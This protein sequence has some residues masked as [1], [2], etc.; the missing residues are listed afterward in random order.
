M[1]LYQDSTFC[2]LKEAAPVPVLT[3][4][5]REHGYVSYADHLQRNHVIPVIQDYDWKQ[6]FGYAGEPDV[7]PSPALSW[8]HPEDQVSLVRF[9]RRDVCRVYYFIEGV[10]NET[11]WL[12]VG[13]LFDGRFFALRA[14]CDYT[15]WG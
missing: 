3:D 12:C 11:N 2:A 1:K 8:A 10:R 5:L 6:A 4:W 13:E 15:G 9:T 14:W 7:D